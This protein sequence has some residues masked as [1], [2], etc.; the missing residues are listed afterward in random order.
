MDDLKGGFNGAGNQQYLYSTLFGKL[1]ISFFS[2]LV[3]ILI[4]VKDMEMSKRVI[5]FSNLIEL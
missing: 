4:K 2:F 5:R 3:E 1:F